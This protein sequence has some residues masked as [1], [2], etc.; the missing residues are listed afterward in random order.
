MIEPISRRLRIRGHVQGVFFRDW[1]IATARELG[2]SG[3]VRN[4]LDGSVEALASGPANRVE[5][6]IAHCH[7]GPGPARVESVAI[8]ETDAPDAPGF[9]R[10]PTG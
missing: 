10:H 1:T 8:E 9:H 3:W 7:D 6:F 5:A 2:L 4:R